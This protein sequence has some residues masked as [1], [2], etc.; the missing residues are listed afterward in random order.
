VP[1]WRL[2]WR[3][4][5][6]TDPWPW[7]AQPASVPVLAWRPPGRSRLGTRDLSS[8]CRDISSRCGSWRSTTSRISRQPGSRRQLLL[9]S[10]SRR[11]RVWIWLLHDLG[12]LGGH[13]RFPGY[14]P[15]SRR[16]HVRRRLPRRSRLASRVD[17]LARAFSHV[18]PRLALRRRPLPDRQ[19]L[20]DSRCCSGP[21][22]RR[23]AAL[24]HRS[25]WRFDGLRR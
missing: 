15:A 4:A 9:D 19:P 25:S 23:Q 2:V 3:L 13:A 12:L 18:A 5:E 16:I 8:C 17:G 11:R 20:L 24:T 1:A 6:H 14:L 21:G 7:P 10:R 22:A